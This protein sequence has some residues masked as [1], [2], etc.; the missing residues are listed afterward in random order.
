MSIVLCGALN[1][2]G[3]DEVGFLWRDGERVVHCCPQ[4]SVVV[5]EETWLHVSLA[6]FPL[7]W[8]CDWTV[9]DELVTSVFS[10]N[11]GAALEQWAAIVADGGR[12]P[13]TTMCSEVLQDA[14]RA[15]P[16]A[17]VCLKPF[18]LLWDVSGTVDPF[19]VCMAL[20]A[21]V[22]E[23]LLLAYVHVQLW[24]STGDT[25]PLCASTSLT[26]ELKRAET[27]CGSPEPAVHDTAR[28]RVYPSKMRKDVASNIRDACNIADAIRFMHSR[29]SV[30]EIAEDPMCFALVD[31]ETGAVL[32]RS[33]DCHVD[34]DM[35]M[36][37]VRRQVK[38]IPED[39]AWFVLI[40]RDSRAHQMAHQIVC[41]STVG[42]CIQDHRRHIV[43]SFS[44][45]VPERVS[46]SPEEVDDHDIAEFH[47]TEGPSCMV[48]YLLTQL[49]A[50]REGFFETWGTTAAKTAISM[51]RLRQAKP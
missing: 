18:R 11:H 19:E 23:T 17:Q 4:V 7:L 6:E 15:F 2:R 32:Y 25:I 28:V 34:W 35:I 51:Y 36:A 3:G 40:S 46:P 20:R 9:L 26:M 16:D 22:L 31:I 13:G 43:G 10:G 49:R 47:L 44:V 21:R 27:R 50:N 14:V 24:A 8:T 42:L 1:W 5:D 37:A 30:A 39:A 29:A 48:D 38:P 41:D 12:G 33:R 45:N